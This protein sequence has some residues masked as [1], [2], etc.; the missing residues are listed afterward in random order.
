MMFGFGKAL[1]AGVNVV[2]WK[3]RI[4]RNRHISNYTK[5]PCM[6]SSIIILLDL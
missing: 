3:A 2:K 6:I 5:E 4:K 1:K